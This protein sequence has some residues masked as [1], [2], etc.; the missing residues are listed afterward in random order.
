MNGEL[1]TGNY[2][3]TTEIQAMVDGYAGYQNAVALVSGSD[4]TV[5]LTAEQLNAISGVSGAD[6]NYESLYVDALINEPDSSFVDPNNPTG[7]EIQSVVSAV[8]AA[9]DA[10]VSTILDV[11]NN[12]QPPTV[13]SEDTFA[14]AGIEGVDSSSL[15]Y[16]TSQIDS[17][18]YTTYDDINNMVANYVNYQAVTDALSPT[19]DPS[20]IDAT[21]LNSIDGV[22]GAVD[23]TETNAFMVKPRQCR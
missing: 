17:G 12:T 5:T 6:P 11:A 20:T 15:A 13:L 16:V 21:G 1:A 23:S 4:T 2:Q 9:G 7:A 14:A 8:T 3:T 19:G 18:A 10:A 22:T